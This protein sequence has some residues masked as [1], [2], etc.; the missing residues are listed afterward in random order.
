M[1]K[2]LVMPDSFKGTLSS[3]E[4]CN[5]MKEQINFHF[6]KCQVVS[7]PV[8]DGGEGTVDC[9]L[10]I[11][12]NAEKVD[13]VSSGPY[14][15]KVNTYYAKIGDTAIIE[16]ASTAGLPMVENNKNP[17]KTTT[18]GVGEMIKKAVNN[19]CKEIILG[20]G[21]SCT[22][23]GGVGMARALGTVFYDENGNEFSPYSDEF[24]KISKID[25]SKT[26]EFLK[27]CKITAMCDINNPLCG[28]NGASYVF[29]PQKG[30]DEE[31]VKELDLNLLHLSKIILKDLDKDVLNM[32][33]S[34][35]GGGI[36]AGVVAFL[37]GNLKSGID[38]ILDF[39][40]FNN[41]V[42]GADMIFTGEGKIDSQSLSGKVV[43]G[44][45]KRAKEKNIPVTAVV[46]TIGEGAEGAYNLGVTSIF[47]INRQAMD[48]EKSRYKSGENL[49]KTMDSILRFY[50]SIK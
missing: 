21:G 1:K 2:C 32:A 39:I 18:Y 14:G 17:R 12:K 19:G 25:N 8:A 3:N 33:G 42:E 26:R 15:E 44:I 4:I 40:D 24:V 50:K 29:A 27:D 46:G 49:E 47:S 7:V 31:T 37:N 35:A 36:G 45:S 38:T 13:V 28:E 22:N 43:I 6:P 11:S 41:I 23:D 5:I 10:A 20:L 16:M 9:F 34:G 30:A 48:F